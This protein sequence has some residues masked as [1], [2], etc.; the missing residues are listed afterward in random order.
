MY[1][2]IENEIFHVHTKR[3]KHAGEEEDYQYVETAIKLGAERIVFMDHCP[4]P[5][6]PFGERM[7][8]EQ[9]PE[10]IESMKALKKEYASGIEILFGLETEY[11]PS[12]QSF[13]KE[14]HDS[15]EFDLLMI[16]Q[17]FYENPDGSFSFHNKDKSEEYVGLSAAMVQGAESGLFDAIAHPD[18]MFR[19]CKEWNRGM[20]KASYDVG[21]AAAENGVLLEKNYS[22]MERK[23]QYWEPFWVRA[24]S[25]LAQLTEGYDAHSVAEMEERFKR[26]HSL[27][28]QE[29]LNRL[30]GG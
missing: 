3:C 9:L 16:G 27:L 11:L 19:R 1:K 17:H 29:E 10:Y 4:F 13:Y 24:C 23:R 7:D 12:F 26:K 5:G 6:N 25:C 14:L 30:L 18:R 15:K 20:M 2:P 21:Y 22:S 28:T 8:I